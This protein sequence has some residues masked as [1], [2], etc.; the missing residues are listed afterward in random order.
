MVRCHVACPFCGLSVSAV[1]SADAQQW[2]LS[3]HSHGGVTCAGS[4]DYAPAATPAPTLA[5]L[6]AP[7]N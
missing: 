7:D 6:D 2:I 4:G 1:W 5:D 3:R